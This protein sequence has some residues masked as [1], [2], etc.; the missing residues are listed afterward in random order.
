[1][2]NDLRKQHEK[3]SGRDT[4][5]VISYQ[6]SEEYARRV[7]AELL[8]SLMLAE[9]LLGQL[10]KMPEERVQIALGPQSSGA[11]RP[12]D[13]APLTSGHCADAESILDFTFHALQGSETRDR[14]PLHEL[15]LQVDRL[16]RQSGR[17]ASAPKRRTARRPDAP[18]E[19]FAALAILRSARQQRSAINSALTSR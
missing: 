13:L 19:R 2:A 12:A 16:R 7:G 4:E 14:K 17:K 9:T 1:M 3:A 5:A 11:R 15:A 6:Q 18:L 8:R 10:G